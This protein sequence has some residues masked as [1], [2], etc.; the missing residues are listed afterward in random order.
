[1][2]IDKLN[3]L[4][5][6]WTRAKTLYEKSNRKQGATMLARVERLIV[7]AL[8]AEGM[9]ENQAKRVIGRMQQGRSVISGMNEIFEWDDDLQAQADNRDEQAEQASLSHGGI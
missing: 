6:R 2:N 4:N 9:T 5:A 1:M 3:G 7:R 8:Q